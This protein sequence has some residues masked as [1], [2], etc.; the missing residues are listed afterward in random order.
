MNVVKL[1][2]KKKTEKPVRLIDVTYIITEISAQSNDENKKHILL[3]FNICIVRHSCFSLF[4]NVGMIIYLTS[5]QTRKECH[6]HS[7]SLL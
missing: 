4:G 1:N 2:F 3:G 6:A 7:R 5:C